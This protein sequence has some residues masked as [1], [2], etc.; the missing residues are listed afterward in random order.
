M[1]PGRIDFASLNK[2][3]VICII[4]TNALTIEES[5]YFIS[6]SVYLM[7]TTNTNM[8]LNIQ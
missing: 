1:L 2:T 7:L 3:L 4:V 5:L 6:F 8:Y